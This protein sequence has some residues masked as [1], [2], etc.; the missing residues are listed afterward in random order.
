MLNEGYVE[1]NIYSS[2]YRSSSAGRSGQRQWQEW[3]QPSRRNF[4]L[5][6]HP[7]PLIK[8]IKIFSLHQLHWI[9]PLTHFGVPL[10]DCSHVAASSSNRSNAFSCK[11]TLEQAAIAQVYMYPSATSLPCFTNISPVHKPPRVDKN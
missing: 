11:D 1:S 9:G 3:R 7:H 4:V 8:S 2:Y 6:T 10:S 5:D